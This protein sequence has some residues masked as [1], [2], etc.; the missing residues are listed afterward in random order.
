MNVVTRRE[1]VWR[2][3]GA[4]LALAGAAGC[5][6]AMAF[7]CTDTQGLTP[8]E[9]AARVAVEYVDRSPDTS[10]VCVSCQQWIPPTGD[11]C[12]GCKV[13]KGPAHPAGW[14]KLYAYRG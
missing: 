4:A 14:C 12:G 1:A 6:K 13:L 11:A 7:T 8:E 10:K 5:R 9:A 2:L 3:G